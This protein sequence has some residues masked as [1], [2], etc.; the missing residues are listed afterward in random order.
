VRLFAFWIS[1]LGTVKW[2]AYK[3]SGAI[4]K[5]QEKF[6]LKSGARGAEK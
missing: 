4:K 6:T 5:A 2:G 1:D 3:K